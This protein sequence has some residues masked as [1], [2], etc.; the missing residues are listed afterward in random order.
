MSIFLDD[1]SHCIPNERIITDPVRCLA[2][3]TDA[4]FYRLVPEVVVVAENE[5]EIQHL[6][7]T[8][9]QHERSLTFR[10][11]GTSLSG[12]A[13]TDS[14]LV[15]LGDSWRTVTLSPQGEHVRLGPA[16]IGAE[17]NRQ[18]APFGRKIGPD[19]ASINTCKIGGIAANN[20]SGM[21]CGTAQNTYRTLAGLRVIL[22]DGTILDSEASSSREN[23]Q[24]THAPLLAALATMSAHVKADTVLAERI[25]KKYS[26]KNTT[27]YSL[28]ALIDFE[29]PIDILTH[30]MI[31]S[32]GTLGF[33]SKI[34][35][36]T[37][38]EP[39]CKASALVLFADIETAC[40]AVSQLKT[41]PVSAVEIMD[42]AALR[43]VETQ[44]GLPLPLAG[45]PDGTTALLI[46]TR[47]GEATALN[48]QIA[49]IE[50][51]LRNFPLASPAEFQREAKHCDALWKVRKGMFPSVGAMRPVGTTVIIEDVAFPLADL[52]AG[53][54]DLQ[55]LFAKHGYTEAIIFGHALE[56]NLH[57]VF[58]QDFSSPEEVARYASFMD[59][60]CDLVVKKYDGSLKAEHGTGRN[61]APFVELEWGQA[62]TELMWEIKRLFDPEALLNPG[63]VLN[64]DDTIHLQNLKPMPAIG[65]TEGAL[66]DR[67]I[68]CGFC[69]PQCPSAG[70]TF[71]PRQR[72]VVSRDLAQMAHEAPGPT[73]FSAE[74]SYRHFG[75][76]TCAGCGLCST[77]CPVGIETG[78]LIREQRATQTGNIARFLGQQAANHFA[79]TSALARH[80]LT[81]G[82]LA[83]KVLGNG[84]VESL[85]GKA[86]KKGLTASKSFTP[87]HIATSSPKP[88][89]EV[90]Y[91][92]GCA[93]RIFGDAGGDD[94]PVVIER[95][96]GK[97]GLGV[98]FPKEQN[99]LCCGQPFFSKGLFAA[100]DQKSKELAEAIHDASDGGRIPVLF[101]ASPCTLRM[102]QYLT[103]TS[104]PLSI[105]DF[106]E[107]AHGALLS[108]LH[109]TPQTAPI[110]LHIN[111]SAKRL[112]QA[113]KLLDV[114]KACA[115][116]VITPAAVKCCGFGGDRGFAEPEL[117]TF[118]LRDLKASLPENCTHGYSSN[119]T[120]EIGLTDNSGI[121]YRSI[122]YLLDA[123][124]T[125]RNSHD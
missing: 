82:K 22:A 1:L 10:A 68:E 125:S 26:I 69:E 42:R 103:T 67:C 21:C 101:D 5:T 74:Q 45:L 31:G 37:V 14:V 88:A 98:R 113:D 16:V 49:A 61:M 118:A 107:F 111:C 106:G 7:V 30:L 89:D 78:A 75:M 6:L 53:T 57:F 93:G 100:A 58:T 81:A 52:A 38:E 110:A 32:E 12:Q 102:R 104:S 94:L 73:R 24:R 59:D 9:R 41:T 48:E 4:S 90:V 119:R 84:F 56:G 65:G 33:L 112:G 15:L 72:I 62:A 114:A 20:A 117:N 25:Q 96:L 19:P 116:T 50:S 99:E 108:R 29:D 79:T 124:A 70:F 120:C 83:S 39:L 47:A 55:A 92:S 64:R 77:V 34:S 60:V 46:E 123:C 87:P 23:F 2:Y 115:Q 97:A 40:K 51:A 35:Y 11:A 76:D 43:S 86:W 85:S 18:L 105:Q 91:F 66:V 54:L 63:V 28:N 17:A 121:P 13:V 122:A 3:G 80:G 27:G 95:L 71:S 109:L 8:A 44:P 36:H